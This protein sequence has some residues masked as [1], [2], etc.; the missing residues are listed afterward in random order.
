[1]YLG[2]IVSSSS[3][4][5]YVC[6]IYGP[7]ETDAVPETIDH[8]FGTFVCIERGDGGSLVGV[9]LNTTLLNPEFGSLG[10]R[11]SSEPELAIFSPDYLCEKVTLVAILVLGTLDCGEA[12]QGV[13][14]VAATIDAQVRRLDEEEIRA[15]HAS[16]VD[17]A[18][19]NLRL[20]YLPTLASMESPLA[21]HLALALLSQL[22]ELFPEHAGQI[23]VLESNLAWRARVEP[24]G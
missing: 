5:E 24:V 3:H 10:P 15:F 21:L 6:Q 2:K 16:G 4:I 8:G 18:T 12:W 9:I 23:S 11:L 14:R 22:G 1:M 17:E 19:A 13:P 7:G 20:A